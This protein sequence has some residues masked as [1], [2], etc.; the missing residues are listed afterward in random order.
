M[1]SAKA[2]N[3]RTDLV[4]TKVL[5]SPA[6]GPVKIQ[7]SLPKTRGWF[8]DR[9]RLLKA[10]V[11]RTTEHVA[12]LPD[13]A[14]SGALREIDRTHDVRHLVSRYRARRKS[15]DGDSAAAAA[16]ER[17]F[18]RADESRAE[19]AHRP[20]MLTGETLAERLGLSRATVDNRRIA[21]KL[22]ALDVGTKRGVRYPDWQCEL[23]K[24][25]TARSAYERVLGVLGTASAWSKYRFFLHVAPELGG[26]TPLEALRARHLD[27]V[28]DAGR[29]WAQ[30]DQGGA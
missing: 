16:L 22:L 19:I 30:A 23:V 2:S 10:L 6:K 27:S 3:P 11:T 20:D 15:R 17:A 21:G 18:L 29:T 8:G 7:M 26:L 4:V 12:A 9:E 24:D 5:R 14:V 1:S 28:V 25:A 13:D